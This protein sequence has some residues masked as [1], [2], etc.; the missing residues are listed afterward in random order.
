M[1]FAVL[2]GIVMLSAGEDPVGK[3][4]DTTTFRGLSAGE[5]PVGELV[6]G[7]R[8]HTTTFRGSD[9]LGGQNYPVKLI[10]GRTV[11]QIPNSGRTN[12]EE[13]CYDDPDCHGVVSNPG[14]CWFRGGPDESP[15]KLLRE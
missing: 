1:Q 12:C 8:Y 5:D 6:E 10:S 3:L 7:E 4:V 11:E 9:S 14:M 13:I 2:A 15:Q